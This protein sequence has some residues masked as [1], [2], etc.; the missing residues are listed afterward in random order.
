MLEVQLFEEIA[1]NTSPN[2][3]KYKFLRLQTQGKT[4]M[5]V[6]TAKEILWF[7]AVADEMRAT[8]KEVI[9]S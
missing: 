9:R 7:I 3:S 1:R 5:V 4:V 2:D 8:S 6:G